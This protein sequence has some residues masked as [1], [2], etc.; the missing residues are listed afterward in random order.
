MLKKLFSSIVALFL[1]SACAT[2]SPN[3]P[4]NVGL[5]GVE[6]VPGEGMELRMLVKLRVQNPN[7]RPVS[8]D[9]I[10]VTLEVRG[11]DLATGVSDASGSV[12]RYGEAVVSVPVTV[13]AFSMLRQV[14]SIVTGDRTKVSMVVRGKLSGTG[15]GSTRFESK[16]EFDLPPGLGGRGVTGAAGTVG[17][18]GTAGILGK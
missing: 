8:Y 17:N 13:S 7:D 6:P 15:F 5:V 4:L 1:L 10:A 18:T 3:D 2:L 9:G 12:P 14:Y 16:G 11:M